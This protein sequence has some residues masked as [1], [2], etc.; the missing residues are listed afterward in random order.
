[1]QSALPK[2]PGGIAIRFRRREHRAQKWAPVMRRKR[3]DHKKMEPHSESTRRRAARVAAIGRGLAVAAFVIAA[4]AG[5]GAATAQVGDL[6]DQPGSAALDAVEK[7]IEN[8]LPP[9]PLPNPLNQQTPPPLTPQA[10]HNGAPVPVTL[11]ARLTA[12]GKDIPTGLSWR[13]FSELPDEG[14]RLPLIAN[15]VGGST[16]FDLKP[17]SYLVHAAYG[18]AGGT[19]RIEVRGATSE[20]IVLNAGGL[21]LHGAIAEDQP[22]KSENVIFEIYSTTEERGEKRRLLVPAAKDNHIVRLN[23]GTYHVVSKYGDVNAVIRADIRVEAGK[24]TDATIYHKAA[25]VTLKLVSEP[26]GEAL[27]NTAW[28]VLSPGGDIVIESVGA[29][30]S[31]VLA[32]GEY[33]VIARHEGETYNRDFTVEPGIDA[34]VEVVAAD[35]SATGGMSGMRGMN[36]PDNMAGQTK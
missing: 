1:M 23:A 11:T 4:L 3:C 2:S 20:A 17:G 28:A 8:T 12:D 24:L 33:S 16:V 9:L 18:G 34:D 15:A 30:P 35:L 10:Q 5:I 21:R 19:K 13:V 7:A 27:A 6:I 25:E 29:F 14:G 36:G 26:G 32:A 31:F 22:I